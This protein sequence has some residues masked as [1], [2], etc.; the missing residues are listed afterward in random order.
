LGIRIINISLLH[1][2]LLT[3]HSKDIRPELDLGSMTMVKVGLCLDTL[4]KLDEIK[5]LISIVGFLDTSNS[6]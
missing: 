6:I 5:G 2:D 1:S 3:N 4:A